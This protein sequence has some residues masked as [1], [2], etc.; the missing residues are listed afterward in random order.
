MLMPA[1]FT[2]TSTPPIS[3]TASAKA[4]CTCCRFETSA[5]SAAARFGSS[6]WIFRRA[7]ASR[8]STHTTDPSSRNR[9]AVAAP[10]PLAPPVIKTRFAF[11]PRTHTSTKENRADQ[12]TCLPANTPSSPNLRSSA[13]SAISA[14]NQ[15]RCEL[16]T[17]S[18][19]LPHRVEHRPIH[20]LHHRAWTIAQLRPCRLA[21]N[22]LDLH[23]D[24]L[25]RTN[26]QLRSLHRVEQVRPSRIDRNSALGHHHVNHLA[27]PRHRRDFIHDHG[28]TIAE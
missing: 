16:D 20:P 24:V 12:D 13:H 18:A 2:S 23:F 11:S 7:S 1:L 17:P 8:S 3:R 21:A 19:N 10:I 5:S 15:D 14:V 26:R 25:N 4:A 27:R 9:A 6:R 22:L 28:N